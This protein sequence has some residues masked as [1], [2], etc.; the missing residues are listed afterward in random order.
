MIAKRPKTS[1]FTL[2]EM[3]LS[4]AILGLLAAGIF[5]LA[6]G[7]IQLTSELGIKSDIQLARQRIVDLCRRNIEALPATA[8]LELR[9]TPQELAPTEIA[10]YN[11]PVAFRFGGSSLPAA[12]VLSSRSDGAGGFML[13]VHYLNSEAAVDYQKGANIEQFVENPSLPLIRNIRSFYWEFYDQQTDEWL[14]EWERNRGRPMFVALNLQMNGE[15]QPSRYVFWLPPRSRPPQFQR[16]TVD[17]NQEVPPNPTDPTDPNI[18][19]DPNSANPNPQDVP[20]P[21]IN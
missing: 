21:S 14:A 10:F 13:R 17:P 16:P 2:L 12:V 19:A 11:H 20:T 6:S 7:S 18:P 4:V 8:S 9:P 5:G 15:A 1:G 3:T